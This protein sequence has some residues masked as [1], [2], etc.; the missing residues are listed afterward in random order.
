M[1]KMIISP[2]ST[3]RELVIESSSESRMIQVPECTQSHGGFSLCE[4]KSVFHSPSSNH[5]HHPIV[6][7]DYNNHKEEKLSSS[8]KLSSSQIT[9]KDED[10]NLGKCSKY[11]ND[12]EKS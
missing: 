6:N 9:K 4:K 1:L 3:T 7:S 2:E 8:D 12:V 10:L 11:H 5:H